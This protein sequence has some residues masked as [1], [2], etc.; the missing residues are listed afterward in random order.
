[1]ESHLINKKIG[2]ARQ[3]SYKVRINGEII[4]IYYLDFLV[5]NKIILEL[6]IGDYF[7]KSNL[8]QIK[9]YLQITGLEL[10]I[11]ANFT[12]RGV[13]FRRILNAKD[14]IK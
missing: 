11:I 6:K 10:A 1:M 4:G 12:S 13:K 8:E 9:S 5:D 14:Y 3:I 2:Y 7:P